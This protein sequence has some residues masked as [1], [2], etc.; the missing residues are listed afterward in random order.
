MYE[1]LIHLTFYLRHIGLQDDLHYDP[2]QKVAS[3]FRHK[4]N[5][6]W[7]IK[8]FLLIVV[9]MLLKYSKSKIFLLLIQIHYGEKDIKT[10]L[11]SLKKTIKKIRNQ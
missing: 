7:H 1:P 11:E 9:C 8:D 2:P 5:C 3:Y 10:N 6:F 4:Q